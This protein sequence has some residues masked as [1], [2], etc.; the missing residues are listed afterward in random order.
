MII[1]IIIFHPISG[2]ESYPGSPKTAG[3]Y[4][5]SAKENLLMTK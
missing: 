1:L 4:S 3:L 2:Y 5:I